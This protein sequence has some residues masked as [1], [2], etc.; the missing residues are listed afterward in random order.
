[1]KRKY[2]AVFIRGSDGS[3]IADGTG[4]S[5]RVAAQRAAADLVANA[6]TNTGKKSYHGLNF[7]VYQVL[8]A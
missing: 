3:I 6:F 4:S 5:Q 1:M 2:R 8:D 7:H